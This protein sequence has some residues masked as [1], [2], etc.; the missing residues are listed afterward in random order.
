MLTIRQSHIERFRQVCQGDYATEEELVQSVQGLWPG[1]DKTSAGKAWHALLASFAD[2]SRGQDIPE[3]V[4]DDGIWMVCVPD[5]ADDGRPTGKE[6]WFEADAAEQAASFVGPGL[7]EVPGERLF[8][9]NTTSGVQEVLVTG[10]CDHILGKMIQDHKTT[11]STPDARDHEAS[12]QWRIYQ[13]LHEAD[14]VQYNLWAFS[15]P[16]ETG[17]CHFKSRTSFRFWRYPSMEKDVQH[18]LARFVDWLYSKRLEKFLSTP[19]P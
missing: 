2:D 9:V 14:C 8:T 1:N 16:K 3:P 7:V 13:L 11:F 5:I 17:Y 19:E 10:T 18:W 12:M 6:W 15:E 4:N